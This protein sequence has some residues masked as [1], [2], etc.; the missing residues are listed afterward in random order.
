MLLFLYIDI[1]FL[2]PVSDNTD[3]LLKN[4]NNTNIAEY[5]V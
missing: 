2:S 5:V 4:V 1:I 3:V